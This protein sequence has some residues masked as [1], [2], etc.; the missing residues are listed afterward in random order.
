MLNSNGDED[1]SVYVTLGS[2]IVM[3]KTQAQQNTRLNYI[4]LS[5]SL[6]Q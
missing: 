6:V 2:L 1:Y 5:G 4:I 3:M